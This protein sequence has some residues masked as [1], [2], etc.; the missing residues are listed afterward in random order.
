MPARRPS[1]DGAA[2]QPAA[3]PG[4]PSPSQ[5]AWLAR[6]L[7]QPGG[8][9]PLFDAQ[10]RVISPRTIEACLRKGW[11]E[12]WLNNPI[13]PDWLVCRLTEKGRRALEEDGPER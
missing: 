7:G 13:K 11:A 4:R 1:P 6:G 10:G 5:R 2:Q 8:K 9:L 3:S 12:R